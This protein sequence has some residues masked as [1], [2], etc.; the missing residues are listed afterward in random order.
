M[1]DL[2]DAI[3]RFLNEYPEDAVM[4]WRRPQRR[5]ASQSRRALDVAVSDLIAASERVRHG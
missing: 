2:T 5:A 3:D 4:E 1:T